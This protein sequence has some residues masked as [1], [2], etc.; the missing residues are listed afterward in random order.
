MAKRFCNILKTEILFNY[1]LTSYELNSYKQKKKK[2]KTQ[3]NSYFSKESRNPRQSTV[4]TTTT[5]KKIK[6]KKNS[7]KK[8]WKQK[9]TGNWIEFNF[10]HLKKLVLILNF[11]YVFFLNFSFAIPLFRC[12]WFTSS[13]VRFRLPFR[14]LFSFNGW[15]WRFFLCC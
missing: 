8:M 12:R 7:K 4:I 10:V 3:C 1:K 14:F 9:K 6:R 11:S 15:I 5:T 13:F 2:K